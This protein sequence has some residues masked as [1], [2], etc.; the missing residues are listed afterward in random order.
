MEDISI[1]LESFGEIMNRQ[2]DLPD[3]KSHILKTHVSM[4]AR[5]QPEL[6]LH[7]ENITFTESA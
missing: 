1:P 2:S 4:K 3:A 5:M 6:V 7:P